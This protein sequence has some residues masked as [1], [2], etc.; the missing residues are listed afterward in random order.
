MSL[1][2]GSLFITGAG[3]FIGR[4][5]LARLKPRHTI[6]I[7]C[8]SRRAS[9]NVA[10]SIPTMNLTWLEGDL[11]DSDRYEH[12]LNSSTTVIHLAAATGKAPA[13]QYFTV[14][15]D[16]TQHLLTRCRER[17]VKKFLAH[18][19]HRGKLSG[20]VAL[21]LRPIEIGRRATR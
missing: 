17:Q 21:L 4:R 5:L 16:G 7:Y 14:N 2:A 6:D 9:M 18:E 10:N 8:L 20:Q 13:E 3:G 12:C 11:F 19:F 1:V 15:R